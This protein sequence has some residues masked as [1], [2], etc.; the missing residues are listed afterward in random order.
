MVGGDVRF[1]HGRH[2]GLLLQARQVHFR[3]SCDDSFVAVGHS[4]GERP[5]RLSTRLGGGTESEVS[6][7]GKDSLNCGHVRL[8]IVQR[9]SLW[10]CGLRSMGGPLRRIFVERLEGGSDETDVADVTL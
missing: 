5:D 2:A 3:W 10:I 7:A 8:Q 9:R 4:H 6:Q 1:R